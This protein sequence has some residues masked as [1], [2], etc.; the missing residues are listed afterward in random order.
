MY[1][2]FYILYQVQSSFKLSSKNSIHEMLFILLF[3]ISA[4]RG[5]F[6]SQPGRHNIKNTRGFCGNY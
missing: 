2:N 6:F 4:D 3:A 5:D 1:I